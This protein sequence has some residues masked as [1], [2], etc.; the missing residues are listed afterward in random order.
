MGREDDSH[1]DVA[2]ELGLLKHSVGYGYTYI[3]NGELPDGF[4][5][6]MSTETP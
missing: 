6:D 2:E 4:K 5:P 1:A 3:Q